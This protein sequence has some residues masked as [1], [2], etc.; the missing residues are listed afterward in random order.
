VNKTQIF[1][2]VILGTIAVS[3]AGLLVAQNER[4]AS[5][6]STPLVVAPRA[7]VVPTQRVTNDPAAQPSPLRVAP[8]PGPLVQTETV[9]R[10][11]KCVNQRT[12]ATVFEL[13]RARNAQFMGQRNNRSF[14]KVDTPSRTVT[15][16]TDVRD[17]NCAF[18]G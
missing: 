3:V 15:F 4:E 9:F 1:G 13:G 16:N 12:R 18:T 2:A 14:W 8:G 6:R 5:P 10:P 17:I 11:F 7:P